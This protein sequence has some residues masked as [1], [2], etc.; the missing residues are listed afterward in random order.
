MENDSA[1]QKL[2][3]ISIARSKLLGE[4]KQSVD[5]SVQ[6]IHQTIAGR[7]RFYK[8]TDIRKEDDGYVSESNSI[9]V[10]KYSFSNIF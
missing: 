9:K 1:V 7:R 10:K 8:Y 3:D 2:V 6:N 4:K 5:S